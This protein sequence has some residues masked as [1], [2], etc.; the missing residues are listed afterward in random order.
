M[1]GKNGEVPGDDA[2]EG[3]AVEWTT[4]SDGLSL[5]P[6]LSYSASTPHTPFSRSA[7]VL[8]LSVLLVGRRA[9]NHSVQA[10]VRVAASAVFAEPSTVNYSITVEVVRPLSL[11][12]P[13]SFLLPFSGVA[14]LPPFS[15]VGG[16]LDHR[17][18]PADPS[19][20]LP[21]LVTLSRDATT[22]TAR[23]PLSPSDAGDDA[24]LVVSSATAGEVQVTSITVSV[25]PLRQLTVSSIPLKRWLCV[26]EV[27]EVEVIAADGLGR[28][29]DGEDGVGG[30]VEVRLSNR[31][32]LKAEVQRGGGKEAGRLGVVKLTALQHAQRGAAY[33]SVVVR[34]SLKGSVV[35]PIYLQLFVSLSPSSSCPSSPS[36]AQISFH[37]PLSYSTFPLKTAKR[38]DLTHRLH[39]DLATALHVPLSTLRVVEVN[40]AS[41]TVK[42]VLAPQGVSEARWHPHQWFLREGEQGVGGG[43]E[44]VVELA[45]RLQAQVRDEKSLWRRKGSTGREVDA[46]RGVDVTAVPFDVDD[47]ASPEAEQ[48]SVWTDERDVDRWERTHDL[49]CTPSPSSSTSTASSSSP[50]S[51]SSFPSSSPLLNSST[52]SSTDADPYEAIALRIHESFQVSPASSSVQ[53]A[54]AFVVTTAAMAVGGAYLVY[55]WM[56]RGKRMAPSFGLWLREALEWLVRGA[57]PLVVPVQGSAVGRSFRQETQALVG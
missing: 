7:V 28:W 34:L 29:F 37:Y 40:P 13:A 2:F 10:Q 11:C 21:A 54:V 27:H 9:G 17:L 51:P 25:R 57:P 4:D 22:V 3:V 49:P 53:S 35:A 32:L 48:G 19:S 44:G 20:T 30:E 50:A 8:G 45:R 5:L 1:E 47:S 56:W 36:A 16:T 46:Q 42:A 39:A 24:V 43:V 31:A 33:S 12:G 23:R 55:W 6:P 15:Q 38:R 26:G 41:Q 14:R 52:S 18:L